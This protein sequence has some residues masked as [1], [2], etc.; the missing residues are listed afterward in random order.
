MYS[1]FLC[2]SRNSVAGWNS[3]HQPRRPRLESVRDKLGWNQKLLKWEGSAHN[4][5]WQV[6]SIHSG[7]N[8]TS[9]QEDHPD[10]PN[11][12]HRDTLP[13]AG[14]L[15][16]ASKHSFGC[17]QGVVWAV[18]CLCV[19]LGLR[20]RDCFGSKRWPPNRVFQVV[21]DRIQDHWMAP[22]R[23]GLWLLRRWKAPRA[24]FME[25][26]GSEIRAWSRRSPPSST[27]P[28]RM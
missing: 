8:E 7:G 26:T 5:V 18:L 15:D 16:C 20:V 22:R 3:L 6:H 25:R 13:I 1:N 12:T 17:N 10:P 14:V 23:N 24:G 28:H 9:I 21:H 11:H 19:G 4:L 27:G 2:H